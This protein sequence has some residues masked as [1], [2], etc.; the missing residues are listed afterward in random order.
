V[1]L[2]DATVLSNFARIERLDLLCLALP[3]AATTLQVL[4]ELER[5][6]ARGDSLDFLRGC[7]SG[8]HTPSS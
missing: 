5:G 7:E 2:L 3:D 6:V 8:S 4:T 1:I